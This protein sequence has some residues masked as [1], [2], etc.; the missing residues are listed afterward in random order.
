[1]PTKEQDRTEGF[2]DRV[3]GKT[4]KIYGEIAD[5]PNAK[6][7]GEADKLKGSFKE[8]KADVKEKIERGLDKV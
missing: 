1:M 7:R 8:A 3:K 2:V 5:D 6:S 4:E